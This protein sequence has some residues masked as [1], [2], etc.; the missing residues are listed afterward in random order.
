MIS[1]CDENSKAIDA[2]INFMPPT[3]NFLTHKIMQGKW[4][5]E[6]REIETHVEKI[7]RA[8]RV[9]GRDSLGVADT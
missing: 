6:G 5:N 3:R 9:P 4:G 8:E 7:V 1:K 2:M